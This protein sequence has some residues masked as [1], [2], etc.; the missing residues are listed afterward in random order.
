MCRRIFN[1]ILALLVIISIGSS[2]YADQVTDNINVFHLKNGHTV[3]IKEIHSNPIVTIDTWVKTGSVNEDKYNNG[4][5]H[6]LEH[7]LFKGTKKHKVGEMDKILESRGGHFNAATSKDFTHF[8][9]TMPSKDFNT[10]LDLHSD[11]LLNAQIPVPELNRER[12]VVQEEIRRAEDNPDRI[13]SDNITKLLFKSHPYRYDTLGTPEI[14]GSIPRSEILKYYHKWYVP[15]NMITVIVGDINTNKVLNLVK[16][17]FAS[18]ATKPVQIQYAR[19]P[20]I[21]KPA[22]IVEKGNYNIGYLDISFK[23][24]PVKDQKTNNS[25]DIAASVLGGGRTSRLYQDIKEKLNLV[26][27]IDAGNESMRDDSIFV[28]DANLDPNNYAIVKTAVIKEI[29]KLKQ[30]ITQEELKRAKTQLQRQ[31]LYNSESTENIANSIGYVMT[32]SG[33]ID[34]YTKYIENLNKITAED[35]KQA[36][37]KYLSPTSAATAVLLPES[38]T[39]GAVPKSHEAYKNVTKYVLNNGATL[40]S[41]KNTSNEIISMSLAIKGGDLIE[42]KPGITDLIAG[43]LLKGT[44]NRTSLQLSKE[45]ENSGIIIAPSSNPDYFEIQVKSTAQDFDKALELLA[46]IVNNPLFKQEDIDNVRT[47]TL[48]GIQASRD[49]PLPL[50][51]EKFYKEMFPNHPYGYVGEVLEKSLPSITRDEIVNFYKDYFIPQNMVIAVSGNVNNKD[52]SDKINAYFPQKEGKIVDIN[53]LKNQF[54]PLDQN[55]SAITPKNIAAAWMIMGWPVPGMTSNKDYASLKIIDSLLGSGLS[56][57]LFVNLREKQGL[58]YQI[59]STYPSRLDTS[60]FMLY[61]GTNPINLKT[62]INGFNNEINKIKCESISAKE[63]NE[64]KQEIIGHFLLSQETNQDKAHY[65][66]WFESVGKGYKFNYNFPDLINSVTIDDV[67][68]VA[69]KYFSYPYVMSIVAPQKSI[70]DLEKDNNSEGK[71]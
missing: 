5:S 52:L 58:A 56:S 11:M 39:V 2:C 19:E 17:K 13:Q 20:E 21:K 50:A 25:L 15:S 65:L 68:Q 36:V 16:E 26:T 3:I 40:I 42:P 48:E 7:L 53:C 44:K 54:I 27:S 8:Y 37:N 71:R 55:K 4:V 69:N 67:K 60:V 10:A 32:I 31:F 51:L 41:E 18:S 6:F 63:L 30:G 22:E 59:S 24:V 47:D 46:D 62:A 1:I 43:T 57:R 29:E 12:K 61:L 38:S 34:F 9:I 64:Q 35:V 23:G 45:L 28:V 33:N 66:A 14:I 49:N 70:M